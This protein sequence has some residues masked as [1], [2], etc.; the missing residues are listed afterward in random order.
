MFKKLSRK[1]DMT[2]W[3]TTIHP[4]RCLE[5]TLHPTHVR[6]L[7]LLFKA[8]FLH[9]YANHDMLPNLQ[10]SVRGMYI[11]H[12]PNSPWAVAKK[13]KQHLFF[14]T[15]SVFPW[16][17]Q[18]QQPQARENELKERRSECMVLLALLRSDSF[19]LHPR[20]ARVFICLKIAIVICTFRKRFQKPATRCSW[21][22]SGSSHTRM[23]CEISLTCSMTLDVLCVTLSLSYRHRNRV[24]ER[25]IV[26]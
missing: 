18:Q 6:V 2:K 21:T 16:L 14:S 19:R 12:V 10:R 9:T 17:N 24:Q 23:T 8:I 7:L 20:C 26:R 1:V 4:T 13:M 5:V 15:P 11:S 3:C 22:T 25:Y